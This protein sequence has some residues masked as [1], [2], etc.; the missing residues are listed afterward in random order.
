[1]WVSCLIQLLVQLVWGRYCD[2]IHR[3]V[4]LRFLYY[5]CGEDCIDV[6]VGTMS[7]TTL[8]AIGVGTLLHA[9][10]KVFV[11]WCGYAFYTIIVPKSV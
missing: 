7:N 1:M 10:V 3:M 6:G 2:S 11:E 9:I 5:Y 4:W 8:R